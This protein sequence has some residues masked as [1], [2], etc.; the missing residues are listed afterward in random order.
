MSDRNDDSVRT[1][2]V[3]AS[4][5]PTG[6]AGRTPGRDAPGAGLTF[7]SVARL[8]LD[9]LLTQLVERAQDVIATQGRLRGLL[10]AT[11]MITTDLRL[12]VLLRLIV[13]AACE[14]LDARYG[15]VGVL[16]PDRRRLEE[17]IHVGMDTDAAE[18]IGHL[19]T[20]HGL[21]GA[22]IDDP[23]PRRAEDI[24]RDP[25]A[26]GF[27]PGH[28]AMRTFLGVPIL[29]RGEV[30]GNLYLTDRRDGQPFTAEDEEL[31]LALAAQAGVA[32]ENARLFQESQARHQWMS[33]AAELVG[34]LT[35]GT[36]T[37]LEL[38]ADRMCAV[39]EAQ[40]CAVVTASAALP[41]HGDDSRAGRTVRLA[42]ALGAGEPNPTGAVIAEDGT[43]VGQAL[44]EQ[45]PILVDDPQLDA[46]DLERG[47]DTASLMVL[48]L[49]GPRHERAIVLLVGR[50]QGRPAFTEFDL[51]MAA[52]CAGHIAVALELAQARAER[53]RLLVADDRGRIARD[54][55][56]H[57][58]QRIF[59]IALGLQD[60]AQYENPTNAGRLATYVEDIDATI[61]D[62]RRTIFELRPGSTGIARG[63]GVRGTLDKIAADARPGLGFVPTVRYAGPVNSVVDASL[64]EHAS[65]VAREALSNVARHARASSVTLAVQV[66]DDQLI[67]E[68]IDDGV[69]MSETTR[70]SGLD[71]LRTR[72]ESL[73]GTFTVTAP[74]G[75]GTHLRWAVPL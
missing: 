74:A 59:A 66:V 51:D 27:P 29:V 53:E 2:G 13:E 48:P 41:A 11:R 14:L 21:L 72:A 56:D 63:G 52:T 31:V 58:I 17:F 62:I 33:T 10:R 6:P 19:P 28:P 65:A 47:E 30:F 22:L 73:G 20:G 4:A 3:T 15:A 54:L 32:I 38:V 8:E 34:L 5:A 1:G 39:G 75:G 49:P 43:L 42:V 64:A 60:L 36:D 9:E 12:P 46:S 67:I 7:P 68:V 61:R 37:P 24:A 70:R 55:H 69:G 45:R 25:H 23:R 26:A 35:T 16:T 71:N 50:D 44:A 57:V 40:Y 18:R